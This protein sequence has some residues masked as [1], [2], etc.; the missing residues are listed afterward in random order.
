[1]RGSRIALLRQIA[2][3]TLGSAVIAAPL[4]AQQ[5]PARSTGAAPTLRFVAAQPNLPPAS[6]PPPSV[7]RLPSPAGA[8]ETHRPVNVFPIDLPTALQLADAENLQVA[9][10]REQ[11]RQAF[12]AQEQAQVLWLPSLRAGVHWNKHDGP[13]QESNGNI[14]DVSR[15]SLYS[16]FGG[17][18]VGAG[19]PMIPGLWAN[20]HLAD[21]IFQPLAARQRTASRS[22]AA[23]ATRNN[24]LLD[25]SLAY[26]ELLR[27]VQD[28]R[29]AEEIRDKTGRLA[30][31][32][33]AY[34]RT[35]QGLRSDAD[36]LRVELL[37]READLLRSREAVRV[38]GARL[39]QMLRLDPCLCLEPLEPTIVPIEMVCNGDCCAL[40]AQ[41]LS[42][43]PELAE[44]RALVAEAIEQM[45]RQRYAPLVPSLMLGASYGGFGGGMGDTIAN[46]D[47]RVD[48]DATAYWELRNLGKGDSAARGL[49]QSQVRQARI[50][51]MAML[52]QVAREVAEAHA[53][54]SARRPQLA[55]TQQAVAVASE[56]Y[57]L[58]VVRIQEAQGLPIE[59]LQSVQALLQARRDYLRALIDYNAAQFT[60]H[61]ALGWP[62]SP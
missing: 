5:A 32:T 45:R 46:F 61:R 31:L 43:R 23:G 38:A 56:S 29:I 26:L 35:G 27:A 62:I 59:A 12:A 41:G 17:Q 2:A 34:A 16:G 52:D 4:A 49:A 20:F 19:S 48:L 37:L 50:R 53:Q 54:V 47:D 30:D 14:R 15:T 24:I 36:R 42:T 1:M 25:V 57:G 55:I 40:V 39:A 3:A 44:N 10:A 22:Y 9:L 28:V 51:Q 6:P 8:P 18:A 58:N 33:Q 13:L 60:L 11:I 21:A 7:E